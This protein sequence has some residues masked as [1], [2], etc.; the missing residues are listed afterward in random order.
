MAFKINTQATQKPILQNIQKPNVQDKNDSITSHNPPPKIQSI[1]PQKVHPNQNLLGKYKTPGNFLN[2][3]SAMGNQFGIKN[4]FNK[5]DEG[6][7]VLLE[8]LQSQNSALSSLDKIP[9][10]SFQESL[11]LEKSIQEMA[12][13]GKLGDLDSATLAE[14]LRKIQ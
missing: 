1:T 14:L 9:E 11:E 4:L 13:K 3:Q 2:T 12:Q 6:A 7:K 8:Y 5:T 10:L